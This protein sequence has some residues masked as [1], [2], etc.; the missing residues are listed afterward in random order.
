MLY[1]PKPMDGE[2][3]EVF[4]SGWQP[5]RSQVIQGHSNNNNNIIIVVGF[6][7]SFCLQVYL[8]HHPSYWGIRSPPDYF[9]LV[10]DLPLP[11]VYK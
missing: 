7:L 3:G 5:R 10:F 2:P 11:D 1:Y 8:A 9:S 4:L 6:G